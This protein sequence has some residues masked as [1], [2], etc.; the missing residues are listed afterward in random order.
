MG[1]LKAAYTDFAL[2]L[3]TGFIAGIV[4][5][6]IFI[7]VYLTYL[8]LL[9]FGIC[10]AISIG[11]SHKLALASAIFIF[12][13]FLGLLRTEYIVTKPDA[14]LEYRDTNEVVTFTGTIFHEPD[15]RETGVRYILSHQEERVLL[16]ASQHAKTNYGDRIRVTGTLV[17]PM[18]SPEFNY[19][20]FLE[21]DGVRSIM[22]NPDIQILSSG[23]GNSI[24]AK[25]LSTKNALRASLR[26]TY[27]S[28]EDSLLAA[29]LLGDKQLL[30]ES[31]SRTLS[32][33]GLRHITAVSGLHITTLLF[34]LLY[35]FIA[36]GFW[37]KQ[38]IYAALF[39]IILY[40]LLIGAPT[41][42]VRAGIMGGLV[43]F[44]ELLGR[45]G[46]SLRFLLYAATLMLFYNPLLLTRDV[47]FQLSF[48]AV[49]G[50]ILWQPII[51]R[52]FE[53]NWISVPIQQ[54]LSIT[55]SAQMLTFPLL[56][57]NFGLFS[58]VSP[59]T[60]MLVVPLLGFILILGFLG[61]LAGLIGSIFGF[62][63]SIPASLLLSYVIFIGD[64]FALL[65]VATL[66]VASLSIYWL[67]PIY[68][69]I[70]YLYTALAPHHPQF[71]SS[72][73]A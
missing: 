41:S 53:R 28:P 57:Y 38:A 70:L 36:L 39:I 26:K 5:G 20:K 15:E 51:I 65:P 17:T 18:V 52:L 66:T 34:I 49:L 29:M 25:L 24:K 50:I 62:L 67:I 19:Q 68:C 8:L 10:L 4:V 14:F 37:K 54:I 31:L 71:H 61:I 40:I 9:L 44:G 42:A 59:I 33:T 13:T 7:S 22:F 55:L 1:K 2:L 30:S 56:L 43:L 21:K 60:N 35:F 11:T 3:A 27:P 12:A 32:V 73:R 58:L 23:N 6:S 46:Q 16:F 69:I 48:L 47:G 45:P 72:F 64:T 63:A